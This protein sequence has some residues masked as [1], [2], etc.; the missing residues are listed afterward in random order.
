MAT[1]TAA[2]M[3]QTARFAEWLKSKREEAGLTQRQL[4]SLGG[5]SPSS[6]EKM[7][8]LPQ[9]LLKYGDD[10]TMVNCPS[11]P[12]RFIECLKVLSRRLGQDCVTEGLEI[13]GH[14]YPLVNGFPDPE[15]DEASEI[16]SD[17]LQGVLSLRSDKLRLVRELIER[18]R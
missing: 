4:A 9:R 16:V 12:D 15:Q 5:V 7:E 3:A 8:T 17:I 13:W 11:K 2:Y 6:I 10:N 1:I 18:L 14:T